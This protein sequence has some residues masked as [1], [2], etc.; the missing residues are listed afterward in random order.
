MTKIFQYVA[1]ASIIALLSSGAF[2]QGAL[3]GVEGLDDRIDDIQEDVDD[4]F[5]KSDDEQRYGA[6]QFA[7]G[8]SGSLSA[9]YSMSSGNTDTTD[10]SV[11]GRL[12][13]GSGPWNHSFGVALEYAEDNGVKSEEEVFATYDVNRYFN[14]KFYVF[15]LG[16]VRYDDFDSN[17]FDAFLGAGPG[18]R[19][20]N[21]DTTTWRVQA[22]PGVRYIEDQLGADTTEVAGIASSRVY[23]EITDA[24]FL[25]NDTDVLYSGT[26][27]LATNEFG[28]NFKVSEALTTRLGYRTEYNSDPLPGLENFDNKLTAALIVGF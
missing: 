24:V 12:R 7:Q 6:N 10:L 14:D 13:Y 16:S 15:G 20:I 17:R 27:T 1:S 23:H 21:N 19:I 3:V 2:A 9:S 25:T 4:E 11:G 18:V 28:V 22:G 5:A 8:W 26:G